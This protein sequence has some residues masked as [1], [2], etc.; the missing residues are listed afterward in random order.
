MS[1]IDWSKAPEGA[2]H[3]V[4]GSWP[5]HKHIGD[6]AWY[7]K[8]DQQDWQQISLCASDVEDEYRKTIVK[9]PDQAWNGVGLPPVGTVCEDDAGN[10]VVIVAHHVNG[11]HAIFAESLDA[12]LLYYGDAGE[13]RPIRT[14]EQIAAEER[15]NAIKDIAALIGGLWASE[16]ECAEFL[17]DAGYRKT[18]AGK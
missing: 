8:E 1:E 10:Q 15:E 7:W 12:G 6:I 16:I 14:P 4:G 2:T 3:W 9:R 5:W 17:Y 11:V 18:E 13:F